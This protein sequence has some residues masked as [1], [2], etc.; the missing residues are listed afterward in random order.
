MGAGETAAVILAAGMGSRMRSATHK[1]VHPLADRPLIRWV[2]GAVREAEADRIIVVVGHAEEQVRAA[3]AGEDVEFV[4]Q[5]QQLGTAHALLQAAPLLGAADTVLVL[6]GDGAL[7]TGGT[8]RRLLA[9]RPAA[10]M[11]LLTAAVEDP[12]GLGRVIRGADGNVEAIVEH[13][14]ASPEELA[15]ND[16]VVGTYAF[17]ADCLRLARS[18]S[19]DNRAGEYYITDLVAAYR[20]E[21][22]PVTAADTPLD[23]YAGVNDRAQLAAS[24]RVLLDRIR[25]RWLAAGVTMHIPETVYIGA[26]V[27]LAEDVT[28]WPGAVLTGDTRVGRGATI[29]AHAVLDGA[30]VAED[31]V[32]PP[33]AAV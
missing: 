15:V 27:R 24:E 30:G 13:R 29:G 33:Q 5:E 8:L 26:D 19:N 6:S 16:I 12:T 23:E 32:V 25:A 21:G 10:G 3:L 31:A 22:L 9:A 14:D 11:T 1:V 17:S 20:S 4:R 28:I 2:T 18:L 7:L